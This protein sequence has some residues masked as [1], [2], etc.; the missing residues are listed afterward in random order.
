MI[1]KSLKIKN[2]RSYEDVQIDFPQGIALFEGDIGSG[3]SSILMAIEFALFGLGSER[4]DALLRIGA[5]EGHVSLKFKV[6]GEEYVVFRS[7]IKARGGIRQ[8]K[9]YIKTKEGIMHLSP[10]EIKEK[11][12][13]ILNFNEPASARAKSVIYRYAIFTPQE[14][15][16]TIL[17]MPHDSRL[18]TLRKALRIEDYKIAESNAS[19]LARYIDKKSIE[20]TSKA[21]DLRS[22]KEELKSKQSMVLKN[23][24]SLEKLLENDKSVEKEYEKLKKEIGQFQ[25]I[26]NELS[27]SKVQIPILKKQIK[28]NKGEIKRIESEINELTKETS[29]KEQRIDELRKV[30]RPA[31]KTEEDLKVELKKIRRVEKYLRENKAAAESKINDYESILKNKVCPTCDRPVDPKNLE[32][33]IRPQIE[34]IKRFSMK[35]KECE[36]KIN[37]IENLQEKLRQYNT[38][39]DE[40]STLMKQFEDKNKKIEKENARIKK[41]SKIVEEDTKKLNKLEK[42]VENFGEISK[43]IAKLES[44]KNKKEKKLRMIKDQISSKRTTIDLLEM[45]IRS[46]IQKIRKKERFK[47]QGENLKEYHIWL[48]DFFIPALENIENHVM[49]SI[50]Q[51]FCEH[52]EKWFNLLVEDPE[53]SATINEDFTPIVEQDGYEQNIEYLSGGEKTSVALAYRLALNNVVQKVATGIRSNLLILDEPT[54]GFSKEQLF[55]LR[56]ILDELECPQIIIVSHEKELESFADHIFKI[57]KIDGD[58][59]I[60][61]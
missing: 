30:K 15:M 10:T 11:I 41:I 50:N 8:D 45:D 4:G 34:E 49:L 27:R 7:L 56:E 28:E 47:A 61:A 25:E 43:E 52:F 19:N 29:D 40:L 33:K 57:E 31:S 3:K 17:Q 18:Q 20:L 32:E 60:S 36:E 59:R 14:E 12:L 38:T 22:D 16:K 44:K 21:S 51:E 26:K 42:K 54:D 2:I 37:E 53:K 5:K 58:S 35:I 48:K 55:K 1:I 13:K 39:R 24:K 6:N 46:L 23:R 9:C